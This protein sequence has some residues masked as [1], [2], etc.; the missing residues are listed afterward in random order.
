MVRKFE[1]CLLGPLTVHR[2]GALV[3]VPR[4]KQRAILATLLLN[5]GRVVRQDEL[6]ES[7]WGRAAAVGT[8]GG[9]ELCDATAEDARR[10]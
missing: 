9:A 2:N 3:S 7:L 5:A 6:A 4:G 1:F 8:G 10:R